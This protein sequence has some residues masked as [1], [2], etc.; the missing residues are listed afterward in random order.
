MDAYQIHQRIFDAWKL[1]APNFSASDVKKQ[2]NTV[3]VYV[4]IE[5]KLVEIKDVTMIRDKVVLKC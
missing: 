1:L 5:G 4:D 2:Y 3:P